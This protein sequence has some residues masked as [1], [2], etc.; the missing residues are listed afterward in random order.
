MP[1]PVQERPDDVEEGVGS[2]Q[3]AGVA[4]SGDDGQGGVGAD[5]GRQSAAVGQV[6]VVALPATTRTGI[7]SRRQLR[8]ERLLGPGAGQAQAGGQARGAYPRAG[9]RRGGLGGQGGEQR[10]LQPP[11]DEG[12]TPSVS[13]GRPAP[14]PLP[15]GRP[16]RCGSSMPPVALTST[17]RRTRSGWRRATCRA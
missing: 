6:G 16:A 14:R 13:T 4:G 17:S 15:G 5:A 7:S 10:S 1:G 12:A 3:M 9:S 11:V 2:L 8:P